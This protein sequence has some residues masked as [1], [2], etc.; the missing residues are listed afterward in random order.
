MRVSSSRSAGA[1]RGGQWS[2]SPG[3]VNQAWGRGVRQGDSQP[4]QPQ[5]IISHT[6]KGSFLLNYLNL[7]VKLNCWIHCYFY[8]L[9]SLRRRWRFLKDLIRYKTFEM[10]VC[11]RMFIKL[12]IS[13]VEGEPTTSS[14]PPP[15]PPPLNVQGNFCLIS[16]DGAAPWTLD[17]RLYFVSLISNILYSCTSLNI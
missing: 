7:K 13:I 4:Q 8:G 3:E 1:G 10:Q 17:C 15:L 2:G 9:P 11:L 6:T 14:R 12:D 16:S 5:P